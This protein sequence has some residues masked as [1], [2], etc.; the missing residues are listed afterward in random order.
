MMQNFQFYTPKSIE[1]ALDF[2]WDKG[3]GCKLIAGG[4]DLIPALRS[5]AILPCHVMN[6][7]E[8][9]QLRGVIE[10]NNCIRIGPTTTFTE[11]IRSEILKQYLP[12]LV[13]AASWVGGPPIRN[14]GTIGGNICNASPA[15]DVLP[16]VIALDAELELQSKGRGTRIFPAGEA[17]EAP[18]K[19][20]FEPDEILTGIFIKKLPPGTRSAFEKLGSR[21][22]M[23]RAYM[24]ISLVLGFGEGHTIS[25]LRI[26]PGAL[27]AVARRAT[28]AERILLGNKAEE[29]VID[30]AAETLVGEMVGV[31]IP[32]YKMPVLKT[33]FKRVLKRLV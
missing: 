15:A 21:N 18:Y 10:E 3:D 11:I 1:E 29:M 13:E 30:E 2:L 32:E 14:R 6:I 31:W 22:A 16:A 20:R 23:A 12:L 7:L 27:E 33:I 5:E 17:V 9:E 4:T 24:N 19:S 26:V 28:A 25:D 8:I